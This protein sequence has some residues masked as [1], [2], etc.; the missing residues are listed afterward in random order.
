MSTPEIMAPDILR[1]PLD[2]GFLRVFEIKTV[3]QRQAQM[4]DP[5]IAIARQPIKTN[6]FVTAE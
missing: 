4:A 5:G 2:V 3:R 6:P 1:Q